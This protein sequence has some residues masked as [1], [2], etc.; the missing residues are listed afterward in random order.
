MEDNKVREEEQSGFTRKR[1]I[2][3]HILTLEQAVYKTRKMKKKKYCAA[4]DIEKAFDSV[5]REEIIKTL[6]N[7]GMEEKI[8]KIIAKIYTNDI[9]IIMKEERK[10][11]DIIKKEE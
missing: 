7:I 3:E 6:N 1:R 9:C 4:I 8:I 10:L 11:A 2:K 5:E